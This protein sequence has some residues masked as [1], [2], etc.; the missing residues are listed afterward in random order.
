MFGLRKIEIYGYFSRLPL[1]AS[2]A[3]FLCGHS[4]TPPIKFLL[5]SKAELDEAQMRLMS[6][7]YRVRTY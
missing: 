4:L 2:Y 5:S 3:S 7:H 1:T 6:T